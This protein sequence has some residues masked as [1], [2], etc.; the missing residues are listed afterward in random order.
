MGVP[1]I[2]IMLHELIKLLHHA[3]CR[4]VVLFRLGTSG[5]VGEFTTSSPTGW[6]QGQPQNRP[7][8]F[9]RVGGSRLTRPHVV[10]FL[11]GL[12][13]G[14]VVVSEKAVD[15]NFLPQFEQVV[16]GKVIM[17][18]TELDAGVSQELLQCSTELPDLPAVIGNTM[19]TDDFYEGESSRSD[20]GFVSA[21]LGL[22]RLKPRRPL[23]LPLSQVKGGWTE[24]SAPSPTRRSWSTCRGPTR[25]ASA[26]SRWSPPPSPPC[27]ACADSKVRPRNTRRFAHFRHRQ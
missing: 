10:A 5:G 11:P 6:L 20:D 21:G 27:A 16:L 22:R 13:P 23:S 19:C 17:R 1:S 26:T 15:Y 7:S 2:S 4:D 3:H 25:R 18:S 12:P 14:T 24:R 8:R 9:K